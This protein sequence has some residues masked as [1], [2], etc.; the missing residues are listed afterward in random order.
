MNYLQML[1]SLGV[2]GAHPGGISLTKEIFEQEKFPINHTI[3]DVGCGTGQSCYYLHQLGY[4]VI[5]LDFDHLMIQQA[6]KRNKECQCEILYVQEDLTSTSLPDQLS[7]I[8]LSESVLNFTNL[9]LTLPELKRILKPN[10]VIIAIEMIRTE[11]LLESEYSE[12]TAFYG[13]PDILSIE[14]WKSAFNKFGLTIFKIQSEDDFSS[15]RSEEPTT[16]F[17]ITDVTPSLA[18]NMLT[19]HEELSLRYRDRLSFRVFYARRSV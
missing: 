1:S 6:K 19:M 13:I 12:I 15:I 17:H 14:D 18:F 16:E 11:P 4:N 7:D 2:G 5:G 10:G 3:L 9:D 8:I